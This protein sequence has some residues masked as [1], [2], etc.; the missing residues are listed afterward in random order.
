VT[1]IIQK[2]RLQTLKKLEQTLERFLVGYADLE[3]DQ[4]GLLKGIETLDDITR[5]S[6]RGR[7]INNR[8]GNWFARHRDFLS[9]D[10]LKESQAAAIG[11][12]LSEIKSGLDSNDPE[13]QKLSDE[14]D[15][16]R[17]KGIVPKRK[18][19]LKLKSGQSEP[20]M[21]ADFL[22]YLRRELAYLDM[23]HSDSNH[24]LTLLD[25]VLKSAEAK[26]DNIYIHLAAS[27][28]YFL[29]MKGYKTGPFV[30]RLKEIEKSRLGMA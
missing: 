6:L 19:I 10:R 1:N 12:L 13:S 26:E 21:M 27:I 4:I 18:L 30:K 29:R 9:T 5:D 2:K 7:S 23:E 14:I 20:N 25:D 24:L 28:I 16:W 17:Q 22:D 11:N 3:N 8:L 15:Q